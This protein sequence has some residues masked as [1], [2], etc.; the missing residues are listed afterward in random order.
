[1]A[2][3]AGQ[4]VLGGIPVT[5]TTGLKGLNMQQ[6]GTAEAALQARTGSLLVHC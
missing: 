4:A 2:C 3:V 6:N 1:M 5:D